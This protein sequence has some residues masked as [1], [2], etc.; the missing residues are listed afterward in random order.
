MP[1]ETWNDCERR[2]RANGAKSYRQLETLILI[3]PIFHFHQAFADADPNRKSAINRLTDEQRA[4]DEE[5]AK[6]KHKSRMQC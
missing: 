1:L 4:S 3:F 2:A 5:K 6:P